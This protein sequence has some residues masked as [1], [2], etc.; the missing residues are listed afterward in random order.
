[1]NL[2]CR[3]LGLADDERLLEVMENAILGGAAF[4]H[5]H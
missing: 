3:R 4:P 1:M 2:F 5:E